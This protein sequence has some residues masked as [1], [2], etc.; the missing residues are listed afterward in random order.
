MFYSVEELYDKS[1]GFV[2]EKSNVFVGPAIEARSR[3]SSSKT[4]FPEIFVD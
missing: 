4:Q 3:V 2:G 1:Y